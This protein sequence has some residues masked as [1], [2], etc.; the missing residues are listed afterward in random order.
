MV[1]S[2]SFATALLLMACGYTDAGS[3][4]Q[5]L[6]ITAD[7]TYVFS[8]DTT[9]VEIEVQKNLERFGGAVVVL[10]DPE[11]SEAFTIPESDHP[12][13]NYRDHL[14][15]FHRSFQLDVNTEG[16]DDY[17]TV[18][19]EGPASF[20]VPTP[21]SG[22]RI[23][24]ADGKFEVTWKP[25]DGLPA[26]QILFRVHNNM[27]NEDFEAQTESDRGTYKLPTTSLDPG[28]ADLYVERVNTV[29]PAGAVS[30]SVFSM[31]YEVRNELLLE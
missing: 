10:T 12:R 30:S 8:D 6:R 22:T 11:S 1:R 26:D 2:F 3:G 7:L 29:A 13:S 4:T 14:D 23:A 24:I 17:L 9:N 19:L 27:T 20:T 15:G 28:P 25:A 16:N 21:I 5:S 18:K 31:G